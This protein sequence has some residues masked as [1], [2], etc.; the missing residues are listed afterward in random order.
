MVSIREPPLQHQPGTVGRMRGKGTPPAPSSEG[1]G[2]EHQG[3]RPTK[4]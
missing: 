2:G 1:Q 4:S 3:A